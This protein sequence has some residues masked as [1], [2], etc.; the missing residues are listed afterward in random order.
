MVLAYEEE[1]VVAK[2]GF[3][4]E[5]VLRLKL[6]EVVTRAYAPAVMAVVGKVLLRVYVTP[7]TRVRVEERETVKV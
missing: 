1:K 5:D 6:E 7:E 3:V 4:I 2:V